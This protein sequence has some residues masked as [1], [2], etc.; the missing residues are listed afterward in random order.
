MLIVEVRIRPSA[1]PQKRDGPHES[2]SVGFLYLN[3]G[4]R[5]SPMQF[6][7][8]NEAVKCGVAILREFDR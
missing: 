3:D 2:N 4:V 7:C 5:L 1:D 6:H 8:A